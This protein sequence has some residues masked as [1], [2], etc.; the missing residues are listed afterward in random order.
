[1]LCVCVSHG[2]FE[3]ISLYVGISCKAYV[4]LGLSLDESHI[5]VF[6]EY[7]V[8]NCI[9]CLQRDGTVATALSVS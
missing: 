6:T 1:M 9:V 2:V 4:K 8:A 5:F 3:S 7:L